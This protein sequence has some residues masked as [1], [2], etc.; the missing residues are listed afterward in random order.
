MMKMTLL[1][2]TMLS[3]AAVATPASAQVFYDPG[4]GAY[5][6]GRDYGSYGYGAYGARRGMGRGNVYSPRGH[7][8]GRDPDPSVRQ[9]LRRDPSQ[10]D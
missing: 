6:F 3:A 5:T 2:A 4:H 9:Q 8:I 1:A 10:G 7:Y